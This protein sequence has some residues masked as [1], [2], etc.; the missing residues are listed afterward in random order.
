M[1]EPKPFIDGASGRT[2]F[3]C[4]DCGQATLGMLPWSYRGTTE[5]QTEAARRYAEEHCWR[6]EGEVADV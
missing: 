2:G 5:Q 3:R 6:P 1:A 4:G